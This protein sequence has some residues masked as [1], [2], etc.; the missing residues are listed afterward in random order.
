MIPRQP[1]Q[2]HVRHNRRV[3]TGNDFAPVPVHVP[4]GIEVLALTAVG[5]EKVKARARQIVVL[6][7]VPFT[8]VGGFVTGFLQTLGPVRILQ[9]QLR[10]VVAHPVRMSVQPRQDGR[11]TR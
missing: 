10:K 6:A 2:R 5:R 7:H 4:F 8:H 9:G 3:I 11:T 1:V